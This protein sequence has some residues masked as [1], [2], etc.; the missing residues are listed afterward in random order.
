MKAKRLVLASLL[1]T[2]LAA[3]SSSGRPRLDT[4]ADAGLTATD[5]GAQAPAG[6]QLRFALASGTYR[7]EHEQKVEV[8][9]DAADPNL[10]RISWDGRQYGLTRRNSYSGLP[11]FED[12]GNSLLW[13]DLPWKSVLLDSSSGQPLANECK[14]A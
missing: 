2:T 7:C 3:C 8:E 13:I 1:V 5:S 14:P 4:A 6:R 12:L 11:R 9:R 10:I